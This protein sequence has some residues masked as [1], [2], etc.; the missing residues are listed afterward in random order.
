M[1]IKF[2]GTFLAYIVIVMAIGALFINFTFEKPLVEYW[3]LLLLPLFGVPILSTVALAK[4]D[5]QA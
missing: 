3:I 1:P 4:I 2:F 5:Q